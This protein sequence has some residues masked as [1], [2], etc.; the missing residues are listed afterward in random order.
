MG[1]EDFEYGIQG[2]LYLK[3]SD[4]KVV[5]WSGLQSVQLS[6]DAETDN[7]EEYAHLNEIES[8]DCKMDCHLSKR[9][10]FF[11]R[12]GANRRMIRR[13]FRWYEKLRRNDV[14][15]HVKY[16]D[17]L[18]TA[19]RYALSKGNNSKKPRMWKAST[20]YYYGKNEKGELEFQHEKNTYFIRERV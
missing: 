16:L 10:Y 18:N 11:L 15:N 13:A 1:E 3:N 9:S 20:I 19:A 6:E 8:F 4:G 14:K 17:N 2:N 12:V 7:N 5:E